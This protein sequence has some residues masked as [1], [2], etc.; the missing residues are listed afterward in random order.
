MSSPAIGL[1]GTLYVGSDDETLY[2][3]NPDGLLKWTFSTNGQI[4]SSPA[5]GA[6]GTGTIVY[7]GS[8]DDNLYAINPDGSQKWAFPTNGQIHSSPAIGTDGTIYVG[9]DDDNLYAINPDSTAKWAHPVQTGAPI[10]SSPVI[11]ANGIIYVGS[12]DGNLYAIDPATGSI[13]P[14]WPLSAGSAIYSTPAIDAN[15]NIYF[16]DTLYIYGTASSMTVTPSAGANGAISPGTAQTVTAGGSLT[17][18]A[19]PNSG[20]T[21]NSWS[22]DGTVTQSGGT[23]F[24]LN[25]IT[26]NHTVNVTFTPLTF[27]I[28]PAAGANGSILPSP[29]QTVNYG[30]S[31]TFTATP[32]TGYLVNS[33]TVDGTVAQAGGSTFTLNNITAN[34]TVNVTFMPESVISL[35]QVRINPTP[36]VQI[37]LLLA[38]QGDENSLAGSIIF[39]PALLGNPQMTLVSDDAAGMLLLNG[40]QVASGQLG[41]GIALPPG[42]TFPAG[43]C[44]LAI[45]TFDVLNTQNIG[46]IPLTFSDQPVS[47]DLSDVNAE[48]IAALWQNGSVTVNHPPVAVY[49][50][51]TLNENTTLTVAGPGVLGNDS[52]PDGDALTAVLVTPP[53]HGTV[54]LNTD[55]SFS[56]TPQHNYVYALGVDSFTYQAYDGLAYSNTA[57]VTLTVN[58]VGYE[59]DVAPRPDGDGTLT[60]ADWVQEGRYIVNLD[61]PAPGSEFMRADCAPRATQGDGKMTVADWVQVGRYAVGLDPFEAIGGPAAPLPGRVAPKEAQKLATSGTRRVVSFIAAPLKCGKPGVVSVTLAAQGNE[62]ALGFGVSFDAKR[63]KFV[64]AKVVGTDRR[65]DAQCERQRRRQRAP[66]GGTHAAAAENLRGRQATRRRVHLPA[67]HARSGAAELQRPGSDSRDRR[68]GCRCTTRRLRQWRGDGAEIVN[69]AG[70]TSST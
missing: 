2:A 4:L 38:A 34:H 51:Y 25:N 3:I 17:F 31:L 24:S 15:G 55:G 41:F 69:G 26:A 60:I 58:P 54:T 59:G 10:E 49:D 16:G 6:D 21:V 1:D 5:I 53:A 39:N 45:L 62:S 70:G 44:Q 18:T 35:A 33:W 36:T 50:A 67:T 47:R 32:N 12:T 30:D 29:A 48:D 20:Y 11:D 61:T 40:S 37:P 46:P 68:P 42:Q 56:Y 43:P 52:D 19:T 28:T 23:S 65:R 57:T 14:G 64:S 7:V 8:E 63:L 22:V 13:I 27:T 9:S 66:R